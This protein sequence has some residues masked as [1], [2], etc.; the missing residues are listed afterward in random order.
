MLWGSAYEG[1]DQ[2][3]YQ[4]HLSALKENGII[5]DTNPSIVE[6]RS[7]VFMMLYRSAKALKLVK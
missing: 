4:K 7:W 2:E 1:T 6:K 5:R 3:W